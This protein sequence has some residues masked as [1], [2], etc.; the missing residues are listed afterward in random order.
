MSSFKEKIPSVLTKTVLS[1]LCVFIVSGTAFAKQESFKLPSADI[2][3]LCLLLAED[4]RQEP[5]YEVLE[6]AK[7]TPVEDCKLCK[8]FF[9]AFGS[10]CKPKK[11]KHK[12]KNEN[13]VVEEAPTRHTEPSTELIHEVSLIFRE[14]EMSFDAL[15]DDERLKVVSA[16]LG[17]IRLAT[18]F[19]PDEKLY[20]S[21]LANFIE[22]PFE[23][24]FRFQ[25]FRNRR[26][27][28]EVRI[29]E[30]IKVFED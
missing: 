5:F 23:K 28:Y 17:H 13:D 21:I 4:G 20:F 1:C 2:K 6:K 16:L 7:D 30:A 12:K 27:K 14:V 24:R 25:Q 18:S 26:K 10:R 8:K 29:G 9:K 19:S 3:K 11:N 22:S 15:D